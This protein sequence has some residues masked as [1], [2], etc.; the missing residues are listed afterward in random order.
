[1]LRHFPIESRGRRKKL[2][3]VY[4]I[5]FNVWSIVSADVVICM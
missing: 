3:E 1:M 2:H 5:S 4:A